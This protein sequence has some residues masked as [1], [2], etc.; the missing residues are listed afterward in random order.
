MTGQDCPQCERRTS[1]AEGEGPPKFC[2]H[3]GFRFVQSDAPTVASVAPPISTQTPGLF[4]TTEYVGPIDP[5]AEHWPETIGPL[6]VVGLLGEG[7]MGRVFEAETPDGDRVA[8]KIL[9]RHMSQNPV[10]LERFRQ[11]GRLASRIVSDRCVFVIAADTDKGTPYIVMEKMPGRTLKDLLDDRGPLPIEEAIAYTLDA[12]DGLREAHR[13]GVIHRDFKPS[14]CFLTPEG[15]V[16]VGDFGLSKSLHVAND[17]TRTGAYLGTVLYSS[18]EQVRGEEVGF[19]SDVY[20]LCASLFQLLTGRTP[21]YHDNPTA[22]LSKIVSEDAPPIRAFRRDIPRSL[23]RIIRK[24]LERDPARRYADLDELRTDLAAEIP[25]KLTLGS[26]GLRIAAYAIDF[27]ILNLLISLPLALA[28]RR[29]EF[30]WA[31]V[32]GKLLY[33]ML[34]EGLLGW[35]VG[36]RALGLRVYRNNTTRPPGL[37]RAMVRSMLFLALIGSAGLAAG[38]LLNVDGGSR[39]LGVLQIPAAFVLAASLGLLVAPMR[40]ANAFRG[41]YEILSG[42]AVRVRPRPPARVRIALPSSSPIEVIAPDPRLPASVG[43]YRLTLAKAIGPGRWLGVGE[44]S[45]LGRRVVVQ[46]WSGEAEAH[47]RPDVN[48]PTR[49]RYLADGSAELPGGGPLTWEAFIAPD[50]APLTLAARVRRLDWAATRLVLEQIAAE[51]EESARDGTAPAELRL[52]QIWVSSDGRAQLTEGAPPNAGDPPLLPRRLLAEAAV[53]ALEGERPGRDH[54]GHP[55]APIPRYAHRFIARLLTASDPVMDDPAAVRRQLERFAGRPTKALRG[56]RIAAGFARGMLC[57][58]PLGGAALA[59][60]SFHVLSVAAAQE[61]LRGLDLLDVARLNPND[62]TTSVSRPG[63]W[64]VLADPELPPVVERLRRSALSELDFH[65]RRMTLF[66]RRLYRAWGLDA[67]AVRVNEATSGFLL[68]KAA[69]RARAEVGAVHRHAVK[70]GRLAL[71][72]DL[73]RDLYWLLGTFA[74]VA[75]LW[76]FLTRG[77]F[78]RPAFGLALVEA[79]GCPARRFRCVIRELILW[80]PFGLGI[81]GAVAVQQSRPELYWVPSVLLGAACLWLAAHAVAGLVR[82]DRA[83]ADRLA[84]TWQVPR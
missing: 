46:L 49:I 84:G 35:S 13:L 28:L 51:L 15:R 7:G 79:D 6:K 24:G 9:F 23:A 68:A 77:G 76:T 3:C 45:V 14:N 10:S 38:E 56:N 69:D 16:K 63:Q 39:S 42:T 36:K 53:C 74:V 72:P 67:G 50:G 12:L 33:F 30:R 61:D 4:A 83:L 31:D 59:A 70:P 29:D 40:R 80:G 8:V 65:G 43:P 75:M 62:V 1:T 78:I 20:S 66:E 37:G 25:S 18:P 71:R 44:D 27:V 48:R 5:D 47:Y 60:A 34:A 26:L 19:A 52:A 64:D 73:A 54:P 22:V 57:L 58:I 81:A 21:F 32:A 2:A 41:V 11:E 17:L 82:P 55:R